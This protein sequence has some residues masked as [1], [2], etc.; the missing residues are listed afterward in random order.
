MK[1]G[2]SIVWNFVIEKAWMDCENRGLHIVNRTAWNQ[3][4]L[5]DAFEPSPDYRDQRDVQYINLGRGTEYGAQRIFQQICGK[6]DYPK[7]SEHSDDPMYYFGPERFSGVN[8]ETFSVIQ[9]SLIKNGAVRKFWIERNIPGRTSSSEGAID[10]R[11]TQSRIA[12]DCNTLKYKYIVN[13]FDSN[14]AD[15]PDK[16]WMSANPGTPEYNFIHGN[17]EVPEYVPPPPRKKYENQKAAR[18]RSACFL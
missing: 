5:P 1:D 17:P 10:A 13:N 4:A 16:D 7:I 15:N 2:Q 6:Q 11:D 12:I 8:G 18:A 3:S 9:R 14:N